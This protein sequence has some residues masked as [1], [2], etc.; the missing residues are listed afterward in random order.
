MQLL[1]EY[2]RAKITHFRKEICESFFQTYKILIFF[3]LSFRIFILKTKCLYFWKSSKLHSCI[4]YCD[5]QGYQAGAR[6]LAQ[7]QTN[8]RIVSS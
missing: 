6:T 5:V 8:I 4:D 3:S 2:I 7:T 1:G